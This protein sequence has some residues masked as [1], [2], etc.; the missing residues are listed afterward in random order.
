MAQRPTSSTA[1]WTTGSRRSCPWPATTASTASSSGP[2]RTRSARPST[3]A[4]RSCPPSARSWRAPR[5]EP[6]AD[7]AELVYAPGL[8]PGGLYARGGSSPFIRTSSESVARLGHFVDAHGRGEDERVVLP[9]RDLDP[10]RVAHAEP[11][12]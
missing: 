11:A 9:G 8:G 1:R 12:L 2:R 3:S 10:V 7:V 4:A 5:L 6:P